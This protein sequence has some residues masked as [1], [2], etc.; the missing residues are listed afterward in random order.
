[1]SGQD[2]LQSNNLVSAYLCRATA[3]LAN[4]NNAWALRVVSDTTS[5]TSVVATSAIP[6]RV[7]YSQL[8]IHIIHWH[9]ALAAF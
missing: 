4:S 5:R 8:A 1:M 6:S 3:L 2:R 7:S 9:Y